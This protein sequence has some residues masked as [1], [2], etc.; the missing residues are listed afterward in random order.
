KESGGVPAVYRAFAHLGAGSDSTATVVAPVG[1]IF[2]GRDDAF[3]KIFYGQ[4][5]EKLSVEEAMLGAQR[6]IGAVPDAVFL[7]HRLGVQ[8]SRD[9]TRGA[10]P[11]ENPVRLNAELKASREFIQALK[12][13]DA[14]FPSSEV[15]SSLIRRTTEKLDSV[16]ESLDQW[17]VVE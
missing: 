4:L 15:E 16:D 2:M 11:A 6:S 3:W 9:A 10:T 12:A 13:I 14:T 7:S 17:R 1:P 5:A 8:F